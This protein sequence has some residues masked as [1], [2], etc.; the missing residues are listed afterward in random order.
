MV[1]YNPIVGDD[2]IR[3]LEILPG[4]GIDVV[5][6]RL[7]TVQFSDAPQY[8]ALSYCWG[9]ALFNMEAYC[10]GE[11]LAITT[12][13]YS[14]LSHLRNDNKLRVLWVDAICINQ[15]DIDER[16]QQVRL[17]R[18]IYEKAEAV[19]VWLGAEAQ[20]TYLGILLV[21][22]LVALADSRRDAMLDR[23]T[24]VKQN[25]AT[26]LRDRGLPVSVFGP[27]CPLHESVLKGAY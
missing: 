12:N 10:N 17:M 20:Y 19:V 15:A 13:L 9:D 2:T 7:R 18:Q 26:V 24:L 1:L 3:L 6:C 21:S 14:A 16:N 8:E 27:F 5:A 11:R 25:T 23:N 4:S 22:K